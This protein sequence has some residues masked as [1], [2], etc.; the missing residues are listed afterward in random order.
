MKGEILDISVSE[1]EDL[2]KAPKPT[3][4][5]GALIEWALTS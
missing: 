1:A 2:Y 5:A 3:W 4:V